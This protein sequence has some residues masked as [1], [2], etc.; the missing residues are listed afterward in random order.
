VRR[1]LS[2]EEFT[3]V[4]E[5]GRLGFETRYTPVRDP[6]GEV[7]GLIGVATDVTERRTLEERLRHAQRMEAIGRLAGG[8]A[9]DFN[10]LLSAI[11]GHSELALARVEPGHP[12]RRSIEEIQKA[13]TRGSLLTRQLLAFS[14][15]DVLTP[16]VVDLNAVVLAIEAM[17]RRLIGEDIEV[18]VMPSPKPAAVYADRGQLEQVLMNLAV[19]ARDAMPRGGCLTIGVENVKLDQ[20]YTQQHADV[21]PGA[22]VMLSVADNGCGMDVETLAHAFEPFYTTK[23]PGKGTGLGLSTVYGIAQQNHGHVNVYSEPG[24]GST[25]KVYFPQVGAPATTAFVSSRS[26]ARASSGTAGPAAAPRLPRL[27]AANA[28]T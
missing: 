25:F 5:V 7:T 10:N 19:N 6:N 22:Y 27:Q 21:S 18:T 9:H 3:E 1:A 28:A 16:A 15:K 8:V 24:L 26:S 11:L 14:R 4:T 12:M 17:L 23:G 20:A 13:G 2:G